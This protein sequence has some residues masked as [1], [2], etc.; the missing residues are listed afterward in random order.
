MAKE[1]ASTGALG[2]NGNRTK[3]K[4]SHGQWSGESASEK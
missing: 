2:P 1:R 3:R 4:A